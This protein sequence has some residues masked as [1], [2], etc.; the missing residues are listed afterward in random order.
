M[1]R[2][3]SDRPTARISLFAARLAIAASIAAFVLLLSLHVLSP[4]FSPAWRMI[5]EYANGQYGWVLSL[6]FAACGLSTLALAV[7][8][9]PQLRAGRGRVGLVLLTIS[10]IEQAA[11]A[12]FDLTQEV[13]HELA[14]A[15]R[16]VCLPIAAMLVGVRPGGT[17]GWA[18]GSKPLLML[19]NLTW[20]SVVLCVASFVVMIATF[21]AAAGGLPATGPE[22]LPPGVVALV[23]WTNR[24]VVVSAWAWVCVAA[25]HVAGWACRRRGRVAQRSMS[26]RICSS[27]VMIRPGWGFDNG[28]RAVG[29]IH[30]STP[31]RRGSAP[32]ELLHLARSGKAD[33]FEQ[34]V[35]PYRGELQAHCYRMLG[36]L[37]DAEDAV[38]ESLIRA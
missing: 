4:E 31:A 32:A 27:S 2:A 24:L 19:A 34:L 12:A 16:I 7:A 33:A 35:A 36:S 13:P 21:I 17:P 10:G 6:M 11:A 5:S 15:L 1:Q 30:R 3:V 28:T 23:G 9:G 8:V 37:H 14:G 38:Q 22:S 25:W 20:I 18:A 29:Q 26:S